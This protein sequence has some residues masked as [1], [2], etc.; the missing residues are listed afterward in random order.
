M[1]TVARFEDLEPQKRRPFYILV[2]QSHAN[3]KK[4]TLVAKDP[5]HPKTTGI[6]R[7]TGGLHLGGLQFPHVPQNSPKMPLQSEGP[8]SE[9]ILCVG[10]PI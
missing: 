6:N 3:K 9:G 8:Q 4:Y 5:K 1:T 2:P 7:I 10:Q